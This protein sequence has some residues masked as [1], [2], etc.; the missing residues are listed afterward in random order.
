MAKRH[1]RKTR[2]PF[3]ERLENRILLYAQ[4][5]ANPAHQWITKQGYDF[6]E[7]QFGESE[8][9]QHLGTVRAYPATDHR[10]END[11]FIEGVFDE[12]ELLENPFGQGDFVPT[13]SLRHFLGARR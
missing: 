4:T 5:A 6:L 7:F 1:Y 11:L 2:R 3:V 8:I 10:N 13:P 12:D 9:S